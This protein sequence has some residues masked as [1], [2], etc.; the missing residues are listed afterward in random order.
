MK[1][2]PPQFGARGTGLHGG[3]VLARPGCAAE[4][5]VTGWRRFGVWLVVGVP[6]DG[7]RPCSLS[8][9][10]GVW[11]HTI[12]VHIPPQSTL[13]GRR[14][15]SRR[16]SSGNAAHPV[17]QGCSAASLTQLSSIVKRYDASTRRLRVRWSNL[18][19]AC[20]CHPRRLSAVHLPP[21]AMARQHDTGEGSQSCRAHTPS[22]L[23]PTSRL[24][25]RRIQPQPTTAVCSR[26]LERGRLEPFRAQLEL[27]AR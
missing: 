10:Y 24:A 18:P 6:D 23:A 14:P 26:P 1:G 17:P 16:L 15:N 2:A 8:W 4:Q 25:S 5:H 11:A 13:F 7:P 12:R 20:C 19:L 9:G 3:R 22:P 27:F 21:A